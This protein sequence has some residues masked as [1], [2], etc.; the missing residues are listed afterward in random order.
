MMKEEL[1]AAFCEGLE[2]VQVPIGYAVGTSFKTEMG[3]NLAFYVCGPNSA[4]MW[5]LQDDGTTVPTIEAMGADLSV[6]AREEAFQ[7]LLSEYG[8]VYDDDT[9][10]VRSGALD[11][12]EIATAAMQFV[13]LLLRV[14]DLALLSTERVHSTWVEEATKMLTGAVAG[15]PA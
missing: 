13:A 3:D 11:R 6:S 4:G 7:T 15:S 10:E 1:C 2:V 8:A 12:T 5:H 9:F 14:Q